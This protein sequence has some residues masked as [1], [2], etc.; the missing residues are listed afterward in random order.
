MKEKIIFF[1][2]GWMDFYRGISNDT[3]KGGGKYVEKE[4]WGHEMYNFTNYEGSVFGYVQ[5]TIDYKYGNP[6]TIKIEKIGASKRDEKIEGVTVVW[7]AKHPNN[8][9]TRIVGWYLNATIYILCSVII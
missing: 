3:I 1:N 9:G 4:G 7:T 6:D 2:T 8:G 5:P